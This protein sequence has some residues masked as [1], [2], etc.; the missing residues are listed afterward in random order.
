VRA[1]SGQEK[2]KPQH[3]YFFEENGRLMRRLGYF[4]DK[5]EYQD[6]L[7][8]SNKINAAFILGEIFGLARALSRLDNFDK[9]FSFF[10]N[11]KNVNEYSKLVDA[12]EN[13]YYS[14]VNGNEKDS[15]EFLLALALLANSFA[16]FTSSA[17]KS[18]KVKGLFD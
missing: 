2:E 8:E 3:K 9:A 7:S 5:L 13:L 12:V 1:L 4:T 17:I 6:F 14:V 15:E 16:D 11:D 10:C 18:I